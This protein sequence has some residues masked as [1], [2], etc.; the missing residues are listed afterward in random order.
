MSYNGLMPTSHTAS[1]TLNTV[2][3]ERGGAGEEQG[4]DEGDGEQPLGLAGEVLYGVISA[5]VIIPVCIRYVIH[6]PIGM[7]AIGCR[8]STAALLSHKRMTV[9][10]GWGAAPASQLSSS[11]IRFSRRTPTSSPSCAYSPPPCTACASYA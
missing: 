9:D 4:G 3:A 11:A 2:D 5:T 7:H 6:I 10:L 1:A 8:C